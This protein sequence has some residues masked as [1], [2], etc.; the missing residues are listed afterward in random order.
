MQTKL[1]L[2]LEEELIEQ[3]KAHAARMGKSVSQVVADY[4]RVLTAEKRPMPKPS[5][6]VT[7]SLRGLLKGAKID[8]MD[9][10]RHLEEKQGGERAQEGKYVLHSRKSAKRLR[11]QT[12]LEESFGAWKD[13]DHS[14]LKEGTEEFVRK[15]RKS[16]RLARSPEFNRVETGDTKDIS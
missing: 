9:F 13:R 7:Q 15:T 8:E 6:P 1:T 14:E 4:L 12:A 11:L 16:S 10:R 5:A 2:R 3:V